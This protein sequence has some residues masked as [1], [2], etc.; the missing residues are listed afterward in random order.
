MIEI[1][2]KNPELFER[3]GIAPPKGVLM[4]GPPG[5]ASES[6]AHFIAINGPEIMSKYVG[7][8]EEN[9]REYFEEAEDNAPSIIFIDELDAIAPKR[10]DTQGEAERRTVAQLLTPLLNYL[11]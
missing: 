7:G 9:L 1:P 8:S 11:P 2:L 4:H 6:D 5:T 3:L 10:E